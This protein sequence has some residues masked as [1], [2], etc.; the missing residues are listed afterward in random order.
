[1][2]DGTVVCGVAVMVHADVCGRGGGVGRGG[3]VKLGVDVLLR[4]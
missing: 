4:W 2:G 1:V 3:A